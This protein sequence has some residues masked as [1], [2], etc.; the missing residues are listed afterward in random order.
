VRGGHLAG[1]GASI[2]LA[3][4]RR[5]IEVNLSQ[6]GR[7]K[8]RNGWRTIATAT[9]ASCDRQSYIRGA[10]APPTTP[11]TNSTSHTRPQQP[12]QQQQQQ[13]QQQHCSAARSAEVHQQAGAQQPARGGGGGGGGV[14]CFV[15]RQPEVLQHRRDSEGVQLELSC[16]RLPPPIDVPAPS[17]QASL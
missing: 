8:G 13:Q 12:Q 6:D 3:K 5:H 7:H 11:R 9:Q 15:H 10:A 4:S 1:R 14:I 17:C 2:F 16:E